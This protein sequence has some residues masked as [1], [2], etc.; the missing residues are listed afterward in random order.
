MAIKAMKL[1]A[2]GSGYAV[3]VV[4]SQITWLL[5]EGEGTQV[6]TG[7]SNLLV[8]E[9]PEQVAAMIEHHTSL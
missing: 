9:A 2:I 5:P 6:R 1:T 4:P 3:Y 8:E 7:G